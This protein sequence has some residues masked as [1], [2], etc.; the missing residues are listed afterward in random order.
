MVPPFGRVSGV[1][2][3]GVGLVGPRASLG[4]THGERS[5]AVAAAAYRKSNPLLSC[6]LTWQLCFACCARWKGQPSCTIKH[7]ICLH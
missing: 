6:M 3:I 1:A 5:V 2:V 4:G 7:F